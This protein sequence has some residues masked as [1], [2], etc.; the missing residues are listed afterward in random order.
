MLNSFLTF[1][2]GRFFPTFPLRNRMNPNKEDPIMK[3]IFT[4]KGMEVSD[5][6]KAL[7]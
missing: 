2:G 7:V 3:Y 5:S 4:G 6:L 1:C